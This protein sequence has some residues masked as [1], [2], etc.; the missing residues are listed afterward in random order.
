MADLLSSMTNI[1]LWDLRQRAPTVSTTVL[2][3]KPFPG[4]YVDERA[5]GQPDEEAVAKLLERRNAVP[6]SHRKGNYKSQARHSAMKTG[7][8]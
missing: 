3:I 5:T 4:F 7:Q 8:T 2:N 1:P 6:I